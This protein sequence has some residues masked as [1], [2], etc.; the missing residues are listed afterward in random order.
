M[1]ED[2][3]ELA[4]A[5]SSARRYAARHTSEALELFKRV[6]SI[7]DSSVE[8]SKEMFAQWEQEAIASFDEIAQG[9]DLDSR[10]LH[11]R[12]ADTISRIASEDALQELAETGLLPEEIA[13]HAAK[14]IP[15]KARAKPSG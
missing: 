5:E 15:G 11:R 8:R 14:T 3:A 12:R 4:R 9:T 6:P 7:E 1:G 10:E 2:P 13:H